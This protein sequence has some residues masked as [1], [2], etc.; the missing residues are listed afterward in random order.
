MRCSLVHHDLDGP[1]PVSFEAISYRWAGSDKTSIVDFGGKVLPIPTSAYDVLRSRVSL[2]R[3]RLVWIDAIC[4]NQDDKDD[5]NQQV[6]LMRD[7]YSKAART[8]V[9]LG[10]TPDAQT[11]FRFMIDMLNQK[12]NH[13]TDLD[14]SLGQAGMKKI[15][16]D[17]PK[18]AALTRM[19]ENPYWFRVWIVQEIVASRQVDILYGGRWFDWTV[20]SSVVCDLKTD[21]PTGLLQ[22]LDLS[23]GMATPPFKAIHQIQVIQNLR[24]DYQAGNKWSLPWILI[25]FSHSQA[26]FGQ[27]HVFG[28]QGI[29]TAVEDNALVPDYG[30]EEL[31]VFRE[32]TLYSLAQP[33]NLMMLS[34]AGIGREKHNRPDNWPSWVP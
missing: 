15:R 14:V 27:D 8:I 5:K 28:F 4:V 32:T 1:D 33:S 26:T 11:V 19:L 21:S 22:K 7:I 31:D 34:V 6:R 12:N 17:N 9:W 10:D 16:D 18:W 2:W 13:M 30:L 23:E 24:A 29:S 3:T 25:S 20:F